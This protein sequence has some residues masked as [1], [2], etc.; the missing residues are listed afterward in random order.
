MKPLRVL[1]VLTPP[2]DPSTGGVQMS[3]YKMASY[4]ASRSMQV[5]VFSFQHHGHAGQNFATLYHALKPGYCIALENLERF[6]ECLRLFRPDIVINQMPYEHSIGERLRDYRNENKALLLACLR[7]TLFSVKLNLNTYR[8]QLVPKGL[9]NF[10]RNSL[11]EFILLQIHRWKHSRDLRRILKDYDYFVMFGEANL[12]ELK[13]FVPDYKQEKIALIPNSI[14]RVAAKLPAKEKVILYL[15]RLSYHQKQAD[16]ILPL[17][18]SICSQLPDWRLQ[19]VGE[20]DALEDLKT[21][22]ATEKTP[23][24]E[25]LGKQLADPYYEQAPIYFMTSSFEGFPNTVIE[26]QSYGAV[27]IIFD[28]YPMASSVIQHGENGYLIKPFSL[29]DMAHHIVQLANHEL[30]RNTMA[31]NALEN[32]ARYTIDSVGEQWIALFEQNKHLMEER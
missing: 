16:L 28:N 6:S 23:R 12:R 15:S 2:F 10:F 8:T 26:A 3:T 24:V 30:L 29:D 20:G 17:W 31:Q 25:L 32:A 4:F 7:N 14:P 22:I 13:Y 19:V 11:G 18:K 27:P 5:A 21:Q 9:Q 1:L